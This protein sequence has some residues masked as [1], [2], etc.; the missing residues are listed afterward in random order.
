[1]ARILSQQWVAYCLYTTPAHQAVLKARQPD[2]RGLFCRVPGPSVSCDLSVFFLLRDEEIIQ[3]F[4]SC[5]TFRIHEKWFE[6]EC[7]KH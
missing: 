6:V 7:N 2:D 4:Q 5:V 1:M 3:R